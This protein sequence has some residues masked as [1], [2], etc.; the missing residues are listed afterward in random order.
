M[1]PREK[2]EEEVNECPLEDEL[3]IL[4]RDLQNGQRR[5]INGLITIIPNDA[6]ILLLLL[7]MDVNAEEE[8]RWQIMTLNCGNGSS[9]D[10][11]LRCVGSPAPPSPVVQVLMTD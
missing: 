4:R 6:F 3:L 9:V 10:M 7:S 11:L 8:P 1:S 2:E 5:P